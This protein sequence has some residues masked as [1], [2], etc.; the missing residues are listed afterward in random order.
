MAP[1][2]RSIEREAGSEVNFIRTWTRPMFIDTMMM[3]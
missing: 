2:H 3:L 1:I